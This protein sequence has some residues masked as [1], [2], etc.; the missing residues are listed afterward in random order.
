MIKK[1][2]YE[3]LEEK[4]NELEKTIEKQSQAEE[5]LQERLEGVL[6][7]SEEH[8]RSFMENAKGF[9]VYRLIVDPE[10]YYRGH[11]IFVSPSLKD[12]IGVSPQD[13]F[14]EWFK[15]VH[16]DDL[17]SLINAQNQSV[18]SGDT[19]DQEFRLR[20]L[21][22][23]WRWI[24]AI[25]NPVFDSEGKPQYYNG[26]MMDV[27]AQ[28]QAEGALQESDKRLNA[29]LDATTETMLLIDREGIVYVANQ[30]VCDRL[31]TT[32][33][34]I[35]GK[36]LYDFFPPDVA[37][38]RKK[39]YNE[40]FNTGKS[41]SFVDS[42][43]GMIFEQ[44]VYPILDDAGQV[45]MVV[46]FANDKTDRKKAEE[47]LQE[48]EAFWKMLLNAIPMPVFF[49][50]RDG[51]YFGV[52]NAFETFFGK[53]KEGLIGKTVFDINPPELA[54]IYCAKDDELFNSG[55][56]Q[57][58]ES[59]MK[60]AHGKLRNII[61]NKAAFTDNKG[62]VTGLIGTIIDITEEKQ[63]LDELGESEAKFKLIAEN[64]IDAVWQID[65][66]NKATYISPSS[67]NIIGYTPDEIMGLENALDIYD[68]ETKT[69]IMNEMSEILRKPIDE[70]KAFVLPRMEG[71]G[72]HKDGHKIWIEAQGK[73]IFEENR[74]AGFQGV[75]RDISD[76]KEAEIALRK[77]EQLLKAIIES[78]E[79][80]IFALNQNGEII[81]AN[82]RFRGMWRIPDE[83]FNRKR[84]Q[85]ILDF[86]V[87]QLKEPDDFFS[88]TQDLYETD[89]EISET[90]Y[91]KDGRIFEWYSRPM[92]TDGRFA[93]RVW[94][95][96]DVTNKMQIEAA[97]LESEKQYRTLVDN[98]PVAVYQN[99]PGPKGKFL[100]VNPAFCKI[101]G[102]NNEEEVKKVSV[103]DIYANPEERKQF[104]DN[105]I[106]KGAIEINERNLVKRDGTP[107]YAS[108]TAS[109]SN[110]KDGNVSHFD[111][112]LLD[113]SEQKITEE[114][115][116][117]SEEKYRTILES[118][119]DGY[120]ELDI[121]GNFTF[122]NDSLCNIFGY[123]ND[124]LMG[125]NNRQYTDEENAKELYQTFNTVYTTGKPEKGFAWEIIRKDGTR[126]SVEASVSLR[127]DSAG[128]RAGFRGIL[129]DVTEKKQKETE[130]INTKNFLQN[131]FD[132]STDGI[133]TTDLQ[134]KVIYFTPNLKEMSGYDPKELTG[135]NMS[136]FYRNGIKETKKIMKE[137]VGKGELTSYETQFQK[138]DGGLVDVLLSASLLRDE[139][140]EVNGT[141]GMFKN[142]TEKKALEA[143]LQRAQ[144][145]EAIGTLAGG[146]AHDLNNILYS[147]DELMGMNNRQ[148]TDEENAKELYQTFNTVYTT[149]K[150]EKGF[151]WEIIRKDGTRRSVEAS[152]SL[153]RDSAGHRA[154]F[155]G[156]LRDVTEKKQKETEL[157]NT[158]NFLQNIFD[159]S[160]DGIVTTDLQGKVI[161]FTPNL[162]EMSGYDPK[163]LTGKN[164]SFFYRNGIKETKK[165]MKELVGKGELTSYETQFQKKDG[166][167]V[168]VLL[169]ASLL[170]DEK[171][172]VNG[173][174]G[175]FKNIT[176]KKALEAQLQR[177]Q[178]MEAIGTLAGGVAH[179]LNNILSG[180]VSYPELLLLQLPEDNP[181][182]DS[183]LTIQKSGEKAAAVVQDL[184]TLARRGVVTTEVANLND[185]ISEYL[186]SPE[187]ENLLS[188]HSGIHIEKHLEKN[189]L[190]I[191]GSPTHLSKTVMNLVSNAAEAMPEGGR[192]TISTENRY[193]DRPIRGYY[194]VAEGDYVV[195]IITD[196]GTGI[197]PDDIE[198]I[199]EPFYTKKEMGRSGTGLG[200]A[201]VWG[202]VKDH[203]GYIDVQSIEGKGT[204]FTLYF[205]ATREKLSTDKSRLAVDSYSGHGESI[206]IVDDVEEQRKIASGMLKELG[207]SVVSIS[208]GEEAVEYLK[209]KKVDLLVL[210]MIMDPG[211]DGLDTYRKI[212]EMNP[213]QKAIIASGFSE[214]DRVKELQNLGAG[215]YIRK[216]FLLEK[217]GLAVKEELEKQADMRL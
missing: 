53:T 132:S 200:M 102:Y 10:D 101:L 168:D 40:V 94:S 66:N 189:V 48:R 113:I 209:T 127:R 156:I 151:A 41:I 129:R 99:T 187:H 31:G 205:P 194:D 78:T 34:G 185:I 192:L 86:I 54:E 120:Y 65:L 119:E 149:G 19:F 184:L 170:R 199:F 148:Y 107:V 114:A 5:S 89:K 181:L 2:T 116:R 18:E 17:P 14:S 4:V 58:Y 117:Q 67:I 36:R 81:N 133:V 29:I 100:M 154:G 45:I 22:R 73:L 122:F 188:Y 21:E 63:A 177:A 9:A 6:R 97:L 82:S 191:L 197:S 28:K 157:I 204:T 142:I 57:V 206:L 104:S 186:E 56:V 96:R 110:D 64:S 105:L 95:F 108:V 163:E 46:I 165:I 109:I 75:S 136:F 217:I 146:V 172:E 79:D 42:R 216:P 76:R 152:V 37:E 131:I 144:K 201:V 33:E 106:E 72:F 210:D 164:M 70:L 130:L 118:I 15:G 87:D 44:N 155:R 166:G 215:R 27:T 24:H 162:K 178:K 193:I 11:V 175:M 214:T 198:K 20:N 190:N 196:T 182:R 180:L 32:K 176:E 211:M 169:S 62:A 84:G 134:G 69:I 160:T 98:L 203:N 55:G 195:L 92:T 71:R 91:F 208:N 158:K 88:K 183:I 121:A 103:A 150:P 143:Q 51:K 161:Y 12:T 159:S 93:G 74:L 61:F 13:E 60:N 125:M 16:E 139:K 179:D 59:Q 90:L 202:T 207:Y 23:G 49:K 123:S 115:L 35:I 171:G 25:S 83:L 145:M 47:A 68:G 128:H 140:G 7:E 167:L 135:K 38:T 112:I 213:G 26:I 212:I 126:R 43:E 3:E 124:E 138:K 39:K 147:N 77:N 80:G 174:L 1:P 141:L 30:I 173:T 50:D 52:N 137:L 153:R 8:L 111:C 85:K